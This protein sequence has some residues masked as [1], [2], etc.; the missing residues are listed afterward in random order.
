MSDVYEFIEPHPSGGTCYVRVT[1]EQVIE[2]QRQVGA[3]KGHVYTNDDEA[4]EDFVAVHWVK[5][6]EHDSALHNPVSLES[7][8]AALPKAPPWHQASAM[9]DFNGYLTSTTVTLEGLRDLA[10]EIGPLSSSFFQRAI[11]ERNRRHLR[12]I[13]DLMTGK[14]DDMGGDDGAGKT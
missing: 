6:V 4:I 2:H 9:L 1:R 10:A 14:L 13:K 7:I 5:E 8:R 3:A 12:F 11:N